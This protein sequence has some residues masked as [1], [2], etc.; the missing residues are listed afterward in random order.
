MLLP[1][2]TPDRA[3]RIA[4]AAGRARILVIGDAMLDKFIVGRVTRISPEP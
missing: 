1:P 4:G 3:R 2:V